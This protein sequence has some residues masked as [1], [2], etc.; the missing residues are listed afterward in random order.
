MIRRLPSL[1][2]AAALVAGCRGS[3]APGSFRGI[4]LQNADGSETVS[5]ASCRTQRCL[6]VYVAPWCGYCRAATP[7]IKE[8]RGILRSRGV[9]SWV[10]VGLD[11]EPSLRTY[12][13]EFGQ[14]ALVDVNRAIDPGG[15]PHFFMVDNSGNVLRHVPGLPPNPAD[16]IAFALKP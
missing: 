8:L 6:T 3:R 11:A 14:G 9:E 16:L 13:R 4:S 5:L 10:I 7:M 1:V 15:V 2:L 12:A